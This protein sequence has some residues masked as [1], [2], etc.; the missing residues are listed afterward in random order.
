NA[1]TDT[2]AAGVKGDGT[3]TI[4]HIERLQFSD[5]A[6]VID[7]LNHAPTGLLTISDATPAEDQLLTV[8]IAGVTDAD[9]VSPTNPTGAI[10][11]PV[12]YF[13]QVETN[14][15]SGRFDD[16]TLFVAG[17]IARVE[18]T[19]FTPTEPFAGGVGID[20]LVGLQLRVRAVYQDGNGVLEQV[21][22]A[23]TAPVA[24]VN[25][26]PGGSLSISDATPTEGETL[27]VLNNITDADGLITATFA[28]QWQQSLNG[29][30]WTDIA[31]AN[32]TTFVPGNFQGGQMLRV[33]ASYIDDHG[34]AE[35]FFG[36]ATGPVQNISGAP[37]GLSLSTFFVSETLAAGGLIAN[38]I[39]DDDPGDSHTF[40]VSDTRF[41]IF[42]DATG[43]H[44]RLAPGARLDDADVGLLSFS[45]TVTDQLGNFGTFPL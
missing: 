11:G 10:T 45:V 1:A 15:G 5:Q 27:S 34:T 9:N 17:E 19:S 18:G 35:T 30:T 23:A 41:E 2:P 16:L 22:S 28:Y 26:P 3:D 32:G 44:L 38:V 33:V 24:N 14:Q 7:G 31:G 21:F 20:S 29:I 8:S 12:S 13:W 36:S 42:H 25:D 43:D 4:R 37:L 6:I 40:D 39:V